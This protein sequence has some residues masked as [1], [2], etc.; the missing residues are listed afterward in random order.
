MILSEARKR[1]VSSALDYD[2][3]F[4]L[5][6]LR[7]FS[8]SLSVFFDKRTALYRWLAVE[9]TAAADTC[10]ARAAELERYTP[11]NQ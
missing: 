4:W 2:S 8:S 3:A 11:E 7:T 10:Y 1:S 9:P 6:F 5:R